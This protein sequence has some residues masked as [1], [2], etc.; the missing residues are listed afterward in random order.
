M[1]PL[2]VEHARLAL[3]LTPALL[4]YAW[5]VR[6][7]NYIQDD[8]YISYRYVANYLNGDG[9]VY[10]IGERVE[11]ITNFGWVIL[12]SLA[13]SLGFDYILVSRLLGFACGGVLL[14]TTLLIARE[15][16]G[17]E[18]RRTGVAAVYIVAVNLSLAYW[19]AAGLETACFAS[20]AMGALYLFLKRSRLL[21]AVLVLSVWMRPEGA[22]L[23]ILFVVIEA[24]LERRFPRYAFGHGLLAFTLSLPYVVF[25][26]AYYGSILPNPFYAKTGFDVGQLL[27]GLQYTGMFLADYGLYGL[28]LLIPALFYR[29]L[30]RA[31]RAVWIF[32]GL[33]VLY[34]TFIGGDVLEVHRFYVTLLAVNAA[35]IVLSLTMVVSRFGARAALGVVLAS[36]LAVMV[37]TWYLPRD[38]V[39]AYREAGVALNRKM[40]FLARQLALVDG[41]E[42]SA[43]AS[44]IG[45]FGYEL[46]GHDI[47]DMVGLTDTMVARHPEPPIPGLTSAWRE[48]KYN[49]GYLMNRAPDYILFS[50]GLK[51]TAPGEKAL[52][53]DRRFES[54]YRTVGWSYRPD[55]ARSFTRL[56]PVF[57]KMRPVPAEAN[58][59]LPVA[60]IEYFK[61]G[62]DYYAAGDHRTALAYYDSA[63][64]SAEPPYN[65]YLRYRAGLSLLMEGRVE[66][67]FRIMDELIADDSLVFEAHRELYTRARLNGDT[68]RAAIHERW[69][70]RLVPWYWPR[71]EELA[72]EQL[73]RWEQMQQQ[74]N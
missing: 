30:N 53:L 44:T 7:L 38:H 19:A 68:A 13:G 66:S 57:K 31:A 58:S 34:I 47:I 59:R 56:E 41:R 46:I 36:V 5:W 1:K 12:M 61:S 24:L 63:F 62:M 39:H 37:L 69:L 23:A 55:P 74:T 27:H 48:P 15:I 71:A 10:N 2:R 28:P 14:W 72:G 21:S 60:Y 32:G 40:S 16:L 4:L 9:L 35:L 3:A 50:T 33:Y 29:R 51:P 26:I 43:A 22:L 25:K 8:A 65:P 17:D 20:L 6:G 70:K 18:F 42:F 11:G 49:T 52:F 64:G 73:R 45:I 67:A 54:V